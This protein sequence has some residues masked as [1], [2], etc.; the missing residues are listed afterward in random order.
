MFDFLNNCC[1]KTVLTT[2]ITCRYAVQNVVTNQT[3]QCQTYLKCQHDKDGTVPSWFTVCK[4]N[5]PSQQQLTPA[6][7][8]APTIQTINIKLA[9]CFAGEAQPAH[10]AELQPC[11]RGLQGAAA[12]VPQPGQLHHHRLVQR[13]AP[14]CP[15]HCGPQLPGGPAWC[16]CQGAPY[17]TILSPCC[18]LLEDIHTQRD[19]LLVMLK[20]CHA[21]CFV[22][23]E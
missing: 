19:S 16:R 15:A 2:V 5:L 3:L 6:R 11:G 1:G 12:Q 7:L 13:M 20:R 23:S 21:M 17:A 18:A 4:C 9:Y 14:G 10:G 8:V 22:S